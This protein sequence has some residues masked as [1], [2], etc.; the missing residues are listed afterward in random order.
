MKTQKD[1]FGALTPSESDRDNRTGA[2]TIHLNESSFI[3]LMPLVQDGWTLVWTPPD[4]S[5]TWKIFSFWEAY[6]NQRSCDGG[7]NATTWLGNGSWTVDHFSKAGAARITN[8]WDEYIID[9]EVADLLRSV[10]NYG[11]SPSH[12]SRL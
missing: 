6:T 3:D 4:L 12:Q 7:V 11:M 10:G 8:F 2:T 9:D 5:K 1:A